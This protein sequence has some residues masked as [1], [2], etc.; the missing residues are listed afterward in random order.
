M[1]AEPGKVLT[2]GI[3]QQKM[4]FMTSSKDVIIFWTSLG[5]KYYIS[6]VDKYAKF[7]SHPKWGPG[8]MFSKRILTITLYILVK[9]I[10]A[11]SHFDFISAWAVCFIFSFYGTTF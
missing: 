9:P 5:Q 8:F 2:F 3:F 7:G 4:V 6:W 11:W 1:F 10:I